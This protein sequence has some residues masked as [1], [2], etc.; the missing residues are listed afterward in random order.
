M[1]H[2]YNRAVDLVVVGASFAGLS[3]AIEAA[4][5]GLKVVVLVYF[6]KNWLVLVLKPSLSLLIQEKSHQNI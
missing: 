5:A 6:K 3:C 1:F 2:S 4:Q